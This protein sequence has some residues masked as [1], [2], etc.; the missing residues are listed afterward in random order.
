MAVIYG[1]SASRALRPGSASRS[2]RRRGN[3]YEGL[4]IFSDPDGDAWAL[5]QLPPRE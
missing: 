2:R 3:R 4:L 1:S 5:Q